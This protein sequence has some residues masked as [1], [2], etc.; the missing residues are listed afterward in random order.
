MASRIAW[1]L[2]LGLPIAAAFVLPAPGASS[3]AS[4]LRFDVTRVPLCLFRT[5]T[6]IP[7]PLCG[8]TRS[9]LSTARGRWRDAFLYHPLGPFLF[10]AFAAGALWQLRPAKRAPPSAPAAES[11]PRT[12]PWFLVPGAAF[13][14]VWVVKLVWIPRTFW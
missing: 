3:P 10:A 12:H 6:G 13:A 2:C 4:G 11:L 1:F 5:V 8:L 9:F 14:A 7:C